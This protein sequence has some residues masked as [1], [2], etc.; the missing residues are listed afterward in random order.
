MDREDQI[1][2]RAYSLW[3]SEG[4]PDGRH[5][6]HWRRAEEEIGGENIATLSSDLP[7]PPEMDLEP[8]PVTDAAKVT[9][10]DVPPAR[11]GQSAK[12]EAPVESGGLDNPVHHVGRQPLDPL[13]K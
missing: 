3:Q 13:T 11:S 9:S 7:G 2:D 8:V 10:E 4:S 5:A 1:R 6:D 12:N